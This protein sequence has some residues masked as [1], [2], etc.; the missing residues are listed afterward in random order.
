MSELRLYFDNNKSLIVYVNHALLG[1]Y[2]SQ[3]KREKCYG[4]NSIWQKHSI[5]YWIYISKK[6]LYCSLSWEFLAS[7]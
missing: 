6:L 5:R 7:Q 1:F 3:S 2:L 4:F